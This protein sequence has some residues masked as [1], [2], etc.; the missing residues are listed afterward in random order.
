MEASH[1]EL[2]H[3]RSMGP[4]KGTP[5]IPLIYRLYNLKAHT[6]EPLEGGKGPYKGPMKLPLER[7]EAGHI[8]VQCGRDEETSKAEATTCDRTV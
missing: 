5:Y 1:C 4:E 6:S 3:L 2:V 7:K 8:R